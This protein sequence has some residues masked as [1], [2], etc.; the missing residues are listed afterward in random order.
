MTSRT[1]LSPETVET[2]DGEIRALVT[3]AQDRVLA[4]L[5][6]HRGVL[7]AVAEELMRQEVITGDRIRELAEAEREGKLPAAPTPEEPLRS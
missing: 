6:E 1:D 5:R 7:D 4:V 3:S 2:I